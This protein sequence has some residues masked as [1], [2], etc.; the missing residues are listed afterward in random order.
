MLRSMAKDNRDSSGDHIW[1]LIPLAALSIPIFAVIDSNVILSAVI[2]AVIA[3][4][5][6]T[7]CGR[8]LISHRHRLKMVEMEAQERIV[9]AERSRLST[10]ERILELD[11]GVAE[12]SEALRRPEDP[13]Q[14]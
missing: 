5:A 2:G 9:L 13:Q 14:A 11:S 7:L 10:A 3:L 4:V 1:I 8:Y 6:V 12:L